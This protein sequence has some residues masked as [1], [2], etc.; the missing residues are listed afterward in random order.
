MLH[1]VCDSLAWLSS[2]LSALVLD[3][4]IEHHPAIVGFCV[5]SPCRVIHVVQHEAIV[6][7]ARVQLVF[8][9]RPTFSPQRES[10]VSRFMT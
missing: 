3:R 10:V 8:G 5:V 7:E 1:L 9:A 6:V 2:W 4:M